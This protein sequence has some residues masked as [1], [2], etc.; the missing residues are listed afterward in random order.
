MTKMTATDEVTKV[1]MYFVTIEIMNSY[2]GR[3]LKRPR[4]GGGKRVPR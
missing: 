2:S 4:L 3:A 1:L